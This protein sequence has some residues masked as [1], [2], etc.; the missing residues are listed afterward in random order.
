[1]ANNIVN[2]CPA[3]DIDGSKIGKSDKRWTEANVRSV[4]TAEITFTASNPLNTAGKLYF[5]NNKLYFN[6]IQLGAG[7]AGGGLDEDQVRDIAQQE[8][9]AAK[10]GLI[11]DIVAELDVPAQISTAVTTA[12]TNLTNDLPDIIVELV[13]ENAD[14]RTEITA[15]IQDVIANSDIV[16]QA[17]EA[18]LSGDALQNAVDTAISALLVSEELATVI[19]DALASFA[20]SPE[21][22]TLINNAI[23]ADAK[24]VNSSLLVRNQALQDKSILREYPA[25]FKNQIDSL[26][27]KIT[28]PNTPVR[29]IVEL[30]TRY[31][32]PDDSE[33]NSLDN[34]LASALKGYIQNNNNLLRDQWETRLKLIAGPRLIFEPEMTI[35]ELNQITA[36]AKSPKELLV[37]EVLLNPFLFDFIKSDDAS[38]ILNTQVTPILNLGGVRVKKFSDYPQNGTY[39]GFAGTPV[40]EDPLH[41]GE[42]WLYRLATDADAPNTI[43]NPIPAWQFYGEILGNNCS[44]ITSILDP[45]GYSTGS[46]D[47]E[48]W[49]DTQK[50]YSLH[51]TELQARK[52]LY[53]NTLT[54]VNNRIG[55]DFLDFEIRATSNSNYTNASETATILLVN[56][57]KTS[58]IGVLKYAINLSAIRNNA[59]QPFVL[60]NV[61]V[62]PLF[63][64]DGDARSNIGVTVDMDGLPDASNIVLP[65]A[66]QP[67]VHQLLGE[68]LDGTSNI[69]KSRINFGI[70]DFDITGESNALYLAKKVTEGLGSLEE[71]YQ[72]LSG[73]H[74]LLLNV[75]IQAV[76]KFYSQVKVAIKDKATVNV[77]GS[78]DTLKEIA[79]ADLSEVISTDIG[80]WAKTVSARNLLPQSTIR[81]ENDKIK[82]EVDSLALNNYLSRRSSSLS[83]NSVFKGINQNSINDLLMVVDLL[84]LPG[85]IAANQME[86]TYDNFPLLCYVETNGLATKYYYYALTSD[87]PFMGASRSGTPNAQLAV[88]YAHHNDTLKESLK[89]LNQQSL[90]IDTL[91]EEF[92]T[93]PVDDL[94]RTVADSSTVGPLSIRHNEL[95]IV[96]S[97]DQVYDIFTCC[98]SYYMM[99]SSVNYLQS[100]YNT[101]L[102][103]N[104]IVL[105]NGVTHEIVIPLLYGKNFFNGAKITVINT[106][107]V[108]VSVTF[109]VF[110]PA[111]ILDN[112]VSESDMFSPN[113]F[114]VK[115]FV[116]DAKAVFTKGVGDFNVKDCIMRVNSQRRKT[117]I[118]A[119]ERPIEFVTNY[120][121][122][123]EQRSGIPIIPMLG[124][125]IDSALI[126]N[127]D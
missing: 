84:T 5:K 27:R 98:K 109:Q 50:I 32:N 31:P 92:P 42:V 22:A 77:L 38:H 104:D 69:A 79:L 115:T 26:W 91:K 90:L 20:N 12:I 99:F 105:A 35:N 54:V 85:V 86:Q 28:L 29:S 11:A 59:S 122:L 3:G 67:R 24:T 9:D 46:H 30:L 56:D 83:S 33:V 45:Y 71:E 52:A 40:L 88:S 110:Y 15:L 101:Y 113:T 6:G 55:P 111:N 89:I 7:G 94:R 34:I 123:V 117:F 82:S 108:R 124:Y 73:L 44:I 114:W 8:I 18:A 39:E 78:L 100:S 53:G 102:I 41:E 14:I 119:A 121:S 47:E 37:Q 120:N 116:Q 112:D 126:G 57:S 87:L 95:P 13:Q 4:A 58:R 103:T 97:V 66:A 65:I 76:C 23:K 64:A 68:I 96:G 48:W 1:M 25:L 72:A 75:T 70:Y 43:V 118:C 36:S 106:S 51:L 81:V 17:V 49:Q 61:D 80:L 125:T 10:A 74:K 107:L 63:D 93:V 16:Q 62:N 19:N 2:V 21:L 60:K 127:D